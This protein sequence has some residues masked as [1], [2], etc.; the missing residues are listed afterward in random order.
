MLSDPFVESITSFSTSLYDPPSLNPSERE[1]PL[2]CTIS[3]RIL[4][5]AARGLTI[6][7]DEENRPWVEQLS[8]S[9]HIK[10]IGTLD[11]EAIT[12]RATLTILGQELLDWLE[13]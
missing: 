10:L 12:I 5:A 8:L 4:V 6:R 3:S 1:M 13:R 7:L 2:P 11:D 9:G